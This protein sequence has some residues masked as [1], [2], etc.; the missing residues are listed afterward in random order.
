ML[1]DP[2]GALARAAEARVDTI[3]TIVYPSDPGEA[4]SLE[5]MPEWSKQAR[6]RLEP[7]GGLPVPRIALAVGCHPHEA[8][9]WDEHADSLLRD[10]VR[11]SGA[12]AI[13]ETG[14]DFHYDHSPRDDQRRAFRDHLRLAHELE[15]PA[16][17]HLREAHEEGIAILEEEGVP[18]RGAVIHCFSEGP[19]L[20]E[21]FVGMGC[22]ISFADD[23]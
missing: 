9:T 5:V 11:C 22:H 10:L 16:I 21:R 14:L 15:L 18:A 12:A 13:G 1:D 3:V 23:R 17:V 8:S 20:A 19:D 6:A 2:V 4:A 7:G